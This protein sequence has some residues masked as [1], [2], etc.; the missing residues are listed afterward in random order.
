M[1][2]VKSLVGVSTIAV[3]FGCSQDSPRENSFATNENVDHTV[4]VAPPPQEAPADIDSL[5]QAAAQ[6]S[7]SEFAR[8]HEGDAELRERLAEL[9]RSQNPPPLEVDQWMN[10][11]PMTLADLKGKVVVLDFWATWCGPCLR[12]VPHTNEMAEKYGD[13]VVIIGVCNQRGSEEMV[14]TAE[15]RGIKYPLAIDV[16]GNTVKSYRVNGYPDY[17]LIDRTGKLRVADCKNAS[18]E[19]AIE[20]LLAEATL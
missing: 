19:E 14:E 15:E 1:H 11:E 8:F 17:F 7:D 13:D 4:D 9:E 18:V 2:R 6:P 5:T 12:A 20:A 10:S 16:D 3:L